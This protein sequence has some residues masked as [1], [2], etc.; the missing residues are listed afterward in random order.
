MAPSGTRIA[1]F[2]MEIA[3]GH[4]SHVECS[5][6]QAA[7]PARADLRARAGAAEGPDALSARRLAAELRISTRTLY[8]QVGKRELLIRALVARHF[9][10]LRLEFHEHEDWET[11]ALYW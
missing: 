11:T 2:T 8:Q 7:D 4:A 9:S 1:Y 6:G 10:Q 5:D 3:L